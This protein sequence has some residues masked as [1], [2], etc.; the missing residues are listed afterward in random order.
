MAFFSLKKIKKKIK[1]KKNDQD[2]FII[3]LLGFSSTEA[4]MREPRRTRYVKRQVVGKG[5]DKIKE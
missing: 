5:K 2:W 1:K 4:L 3:K